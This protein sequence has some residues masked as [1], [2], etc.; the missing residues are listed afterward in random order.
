MFQSVQKYN[1]ANHY[2]FVV[3]TRDYHP[4][5]NWEAVISVGGAQFYKSIKIETIKPNRLKIKN[6]FLNNQF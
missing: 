6:T 3:A 5:G 2:K 4:T 1:D